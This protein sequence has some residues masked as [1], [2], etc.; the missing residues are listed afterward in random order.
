[1]TPSL[2]VGE[3]QLHAIKL[4]SALVIQPGTD[5]L[6]GLSEILMPMLA[7]ALD[8]SEAVPT[9]SSDPDPSCTMKPLN[10]CEHATD[11]NHKDSL[12]PAAMRLLS[13][14]M[15]RYMMEQT[16]KNGIEKILPD[17]VGF[18][19]RL[20]KLQFKCL[21]RHCCQPL[22][23]MFLIMMAMFACLFRGYKNVIRN[24]DATHQAFVQGRLSANFAT[25]LASRV[26][27]GINCILISIQMS[28]WN[29]ECRC[30][31]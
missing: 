21:R 26:I 31:S 1:M 20:L 23:P 18:G 13:L 2:Y 30:H 11:G 28:C 19:R 27:A 6:K 17:D 7:D 5:S 10:S 15:A 8:L 3:E 22:A 4:A 12:V 9:Q 25:H 24:G 29:E 14:L 16:N